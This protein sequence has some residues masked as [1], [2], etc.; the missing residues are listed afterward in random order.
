MW[1][2]WNY[3]DSHIPQN[4]LGRADTKMLEKIGKDI[5]LENVVK[6]GE[7]VLKDRQ[8]E[9]FL[10]YTALTWKEL[11]F[12]RSRST[13]DVMNS[14]P[15]EYWYRSKIPVKSVEDLLVATWKGMTA[16]L[17]LHRPPEAGAHPPPQSV[18]ITPGTP[19]VGTK[20]KH[21]TFHQSSAKAH[22]SVPRSIKPTPLR[23]GEPSSA[24]TCSIACR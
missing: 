19:R 9:M 11:A 1:S 8:L 3:S 2:W 15:E 23:P 16:T 21:V 6:D 17:G 5:S 13:D 24:K 7:I 14:K 20:R 18:L 22:T 10:L 12:M 4:I